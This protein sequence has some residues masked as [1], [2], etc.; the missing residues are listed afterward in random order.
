MAQL[1][2]WESFYVI[3][4][5]AAGTLIGLQFIVLT[6]IGSRRGQR[7]AETSA[8]FVTPTIAHFSAALLIAALMRAPWPKP[9]P[10][11]ALCSAVGLAGVAYVFVVHRLMR[12]QA[13][14]QPV[15]EDWLFHFILPFLAYAALVVS[16]MLMV[17]ATQLA[18][19]GVGAGA[20]MLVFIGIHNA[21]DDIAYL[22]FVNPLGGDDRA[23]SH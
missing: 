11:E 21:W 4:A 2:A 9:A 15:L 16:A 12:Q 10:V 7:V 1:A 20:L 5:T 6:L 17:T 3:T 22:V 19:F 13:G 14:Y 18:L 23:E 8:A